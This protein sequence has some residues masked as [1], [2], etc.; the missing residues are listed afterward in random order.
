M[1]IVIKVTFGQVS[2][3]NYWLNIHRRELGNG[4]ILVESKLFYINALD[5]NLTN[6]IVW[7]QL[8]DATPRYA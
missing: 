4:N 1:N 8:G 2:R 7:F 6:I 5:P 3:A